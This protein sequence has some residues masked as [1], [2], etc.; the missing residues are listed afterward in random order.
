V[1]HQADALAP[2]AANVHVE[3]AVLGVVV[4]EGQAVLLCESLALGLV[5]ELV[6]QQLVAVGG[7]GAE[8]EAERLALLEELGGGIGLEDELVAVLAAKDS[9]EG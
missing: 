4:G 5:E 2:G 8:E 9:D 3:V 1:L 7:D 6:D